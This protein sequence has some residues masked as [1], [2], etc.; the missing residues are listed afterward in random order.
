MGPLGGILSGI[1]SG[2]G[3]ALGGIGGGIGALGGAAG[4][5]LG[6]VGGM[7]GGLLT[8][9][10][11]QKG[12]GS[13]VG[14][15]A[16]MF[17][18]SRPLSTGSGATTN[19][20]QQ[21]GQAATQ[22]ASG[23]GD[24]A[25]TNFN[26]S[27]GMVADP[28]S[29]MMGGRVS[30]SRHTD[31]GAPFFPPGHAMVRNPH[32]SIVANTPNVNPYLGKTQNMTPPIARDSNWEEAVRRNQVSHAPEW[33]PPSISGGW[34]HNSPSA[35]HA[36]GNPISPVPLENY[37]TNN[38]TVKYQS[39]WGDALPGFAG[40]VL[41]GFQDRLRGMAPY[42]GGGGGNLFGRGSEDGEINR[43]NF[44]KT[45]MMQSLLGGVGSI[46]APNNIMSQIWGGVTNPMFQNIA[47]QQ[48]QAGLAGMFNQTLIAQLMKQLG[49]LPESAATGEEETADPNAPIVDPNAPIV[50]DPSELGTVES[51]NFNPDPPSPGINL[52]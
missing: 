43:E 36:A 47:N 16:N 26:N 52:R 7:A 14:G 29:N 20:A 4:N 28:I 19:P 23:L 40:D 38:P 46:L 27:G 21:A 33:N 39:D 10:L 6:N 11:V 2:V 5:I 34:E 41:G 37:S 25:N 49:L 24:I 48:Q 9:S 8:P 13:A 15:L 22:P 12:L 3:G 35:H 50:T 1:G 42:F 51:M 17:G 45:N 18:G 31:I 32:S 44:A 30:G